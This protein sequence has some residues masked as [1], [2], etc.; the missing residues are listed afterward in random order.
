MRRFTFHLH[1]G[2]DGRTYVRTIDDVM[3]IKS[4]FLRSMGYQYFLSYGAPRARSSASTATNV[5]KNKLRGIKYVVIF[6]VFLSFTFKWFSLKILAIFFCFHTIWNEYK[7]TNLV[8]FSTRTASS[9][10]LDLP[11]DSFPPFDPSQL[12]EYECSVKF[13]FSFREQNTVFCFF[14]V[15]LLW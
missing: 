11:C 12:N 14:D 13:F 9:P 10:K 2:A 6:V 8:F 4:N 15:S 1:E 7:T 3:A 5:K